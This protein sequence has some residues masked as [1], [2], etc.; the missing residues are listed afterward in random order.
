MLPEESRRPMI[1]RGTLLLATLPPYKAIWSGTRR[2][3]AGLPSSA[4]QML[5]KF[6]P[7]FVFPS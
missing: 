5:I 1:G 2:S 7:P 3:L 4:L 6:L